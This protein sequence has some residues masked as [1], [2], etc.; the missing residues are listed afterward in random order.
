M[1]VI[2]RRENEKFLFPNLGISIQVIKVA[3][4]VARIG[5]DAPKNIRVLREELADRQPDAQ[6]PEDLQ[7]LAGSLPA[8][9]KHQFRNR[10]N[11]ISLGLQ[12]AQKQIET[13]QTKNLENV[14]QKLVNELKNLDRDLGGDELHA[15]G[16]AG[17]RFL[18][19]ISKTDPCE[20]K[21]AL[22]VDDNANE[23]S[24]MCTLLELS[25]YDV[26]MVEDGQAAIDYLSQSFR[27]PDFVLLDMNMPRKDGSQTIAEIRSNP[28]FCGLKV[29]AVS[30]SD[31][32]DLNVTIGPKGVDRW[33]T[34]PLDAKQ[35]VSEMNR[36][37]QTA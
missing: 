16:L 9:L 25:G 3:G 24:L 2:S 10:L 21:M 32:H 31:Q 17:E 28:E 13:G 1:L 4:K 7:S 29:F 23:R 5:V 34:K 6:L 36:Q 18:N 30:G 19:A 15:G 12:I 27:L 20:S 22:V 33:F 11:P 26:V 14:V 8:N 37:T 35:L